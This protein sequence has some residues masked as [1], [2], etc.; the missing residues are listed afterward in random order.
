[1]TNQ[2][3]SALIRR[4]GN[5]RPCAGAI[6]IC[7]AI[8]GALVAPLPANAGL[9]ILT[10]ERSV[11]AH[12][13]SFCP[14]CGDNGEDVIFS[15]GDT[16]STLNTGSFIES[17]FSVGSASGQSSFVSPGGVSGNGGI[18]TGS[19]GNNNADSRITME[20]TPQTSGLVHLS[21]EITVNNNDQDCV[22]FVG[23]SDGNGF[24]FS[25]EVMFTSDTTMFDEMIALQ[26]GTIYTLQIYS[27]GMDFEGTGSGASWS[28]NMTPEP[29][30]ALL[31]LAVG[32]ACRRR[33]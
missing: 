11:D 13:T 7:A 2:K 10:I 3:Q 27:A 29:A 19:T 16:I 24:L 26:A 1:M 6:L 22:S 14:G 32:I 23:I 20:F 31:L 15:N 5:E 21:G 33:R 9:M 17:V 28:I 25:Q 8:A 30:G 18:D 4:N 12:G